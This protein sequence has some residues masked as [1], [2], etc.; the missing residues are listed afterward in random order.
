MIL[1]TDK[2]WVGDRRPKK[3]RDGGGLAQ[4]TPPGGG[5]HGDWG[6]RHRLWK[7]EF[8]T[9]PRLLKLSL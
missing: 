2:S 6:S 3:I 7:V 1:A 8:S 9:H 4:R 5:G